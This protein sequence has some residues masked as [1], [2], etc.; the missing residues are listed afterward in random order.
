MK[1]AT[2]I[3][4]FI[5]MLLSVYSVCFAESSNTVAVPESFDYEKLKTMTYVSEDDME[6]RAFVYYSSVHVPNTGRTEIEGSYARTRFSSFIVPDIIIINLGTAKESPLFRI[7]IYYKNSE[8]LFAD[9]CIIKVGD[10]RYYFGGI[11]VQRDTGYSKYSG[12]WI[13]EILLIKIGDDSIPFMEDLCE[14]KENDETVMLR[15]KGSKGYIDFD[16]TSNISYITDLYEQ[17]KKCG[18]TLERYTTQFEENIQ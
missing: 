2:A 11:D 12:S 10:E 18:G 8:W 3:M 4:I 16:I 17:L 13:E 15:L 5:V 6:G 7:W 14:A 1:K 9:N